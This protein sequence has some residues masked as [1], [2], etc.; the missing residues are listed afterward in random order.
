MNGLRH[1]LVGTD[2]S[3]SSQAALDA[4]RNLARSAGAKLTVLHVTSPGAQALGAAGMEERMEIGH[5]VHE[6]VVELKDK[7]GGVAD[8]KVE[9]VSGPSPAAAIV[10]YAAAHGVDLIVVGSHGREAIGR[11]LIGSSADRVV[12]HAPCSVLVARNPAN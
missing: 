9:V 5:K 8:S 12:H 4:G 3:S 6:A 1:I 2:F 10:D 7:L 11:F